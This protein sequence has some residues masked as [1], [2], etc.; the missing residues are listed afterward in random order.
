[1]RVS[2]G[3]PHGVTG[4]LFEE[5]R[6]RRR[7]EAAFVEELQDAGYSEVILPI[8]DYSEPYEPLLT[9]S[10]REQLYRFVDRDGELLVLRADFTPLLARLLAPRLGTLELPLRAFYRGDVVRHQEVRPGRLREYYAVGAELLGGD[11]ETADGEILRLFVRLVSR[12]RI[13][14]MRVV[15]G[16][17]GALDE[18]LGRASADGSAGASV[19]GGAAMAAAISRR[20]RQAARRGEAALVEVVEQGVPRHAESLGPVASKRLERLLALARRLGGELAEEGVEL[21]VDLA[22]FAANT[23]RP[24]LEVPGSMW[25]YYDGI[26]FRAYH[27]ESGREVARGGRYDR[28]FEALGADVP[29]VGFSLGV[30]GL[31]QISGGVEGER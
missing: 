31:V 8:L 4:I 3:L 21:A 18:L 11:R 12:A 20:D 27:A 16:F 1:M 17:A 24:E 10:T 25:T 23:L 13:G 6:E 22:E 29:A 7:L 19:G 2:A 14:P 30:D 5:A 9:A 28:L 15:L 26:V